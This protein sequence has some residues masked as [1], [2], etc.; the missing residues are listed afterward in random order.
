MV[1]YFAYIE[2]GILIMKLN[3]AD[4][5]NDSNILSKS[6]NKSFKIAE[7]QDDCFRGKITLIQLNKVKKKFIAKRPDGRE[8]RVID[9]NYKIL[10]FFPEK[11]SYCFSAMYNSNCNILQW[12]F[13]ILKSDCKYNSG[14][15]YGEDMYLD[16]VVLPNGEF[17]ILDEDELKDALDKKIITIDDYTRA[18]KTMKSIEN[19]LNSNFNKLKNFT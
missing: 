4:R 11:G 1:E 2:R 19:M 16:V 8:E 7:S 5:Q 18:Y 12:Y 15:P 6:F 14:I 17:Y 3:Y 9:D 13:D 10:T